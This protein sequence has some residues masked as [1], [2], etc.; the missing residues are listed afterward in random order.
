MPNFR[1]V[2]GL[3]RRRRNPALI[4]DANLIAGSSEN[5]RQFHVLDSSIQTNNSIGIAPTT[6]NNNL[7]DQ[8]IL[9]EI[10]LIVYR[11]E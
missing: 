11:L 6:L 9:F 5:S 1:R 10:K 4:L 7:H 2:H 3:I 8:V